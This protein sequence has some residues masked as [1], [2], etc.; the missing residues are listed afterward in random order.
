MDRQTPTGPLTILP[1]HTRRLSNEDATE[2]TITSA[3]AMADVVRS[4]LGPEG[5]DTMLVTSHG[6]VLVTNDGST[7]LQELH[8]TNPA[9]RLVADVASTQ[10][11][12]ASDGTTTA[13]VLAGEL[14]RRASGLLDQGLHP[15]TVAEGYR[16]ATARAVDLVDEQAVTIDPGD[17]AELTR[18]AAT[19]MTGTTTEQH[20]DALRPLAVEAVRKVTVE[21]DGNRIVDLHSLHI[22]SSEVG[23]HPGDSALL[24]GAVVFADP[25]HEAMPTS[26]EHAD[27]LLLDHP[28]EPAE[29]TVDATLHV[30][31]VDDHRR[32]RDGERRQATEIA[33]PILDSGVDV[34]FCGEHIDEAVQHE[35]ARAGILAVRRTRSDDMAFL[36]E[37]LGG[38][39]YTDPDA[40]D[41]DALVTGHVRRGEG[42]RAFHVEA[43][44]EATHGVT[45]LLRGS[46]RHALNEIER[47]V[48]DA[49]DT[50]ARAVSDGVVLPGA[51]ATEVA[52]AA[53]VR[54]HA[55]GVGGREQLAIEAFADALEVVPTV[56]AENAGLDPIDVLTDLRAAHRDGNERV[57]LNVRTGALEDAIE[58]GIYDL[59]GVKRQS[60]TAAGEIATFLL[61]I[62]DVISADDLTDGDVPDDD[63]NGDGDG[64][65]GPAGGLAGPTGGAI[66]SAAAKRRGDG[67]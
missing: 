67:S 29:P 63:E 33:R 7:L 1:N 23:G 55:A 57:G 53:G 56:L 17:D 22:E 58:A 49:I 39:I 37:V 66:E 38:E 30:E 60:I 34:V 9:A 32:F 45:F 46:I 25:V 2:Y 27:V 12:E 15:T 42:G 11:A 35:L 24:D 3:T 50:V 6:N 26:V 8:V 43:A 20:A 19:A 61:K 48:E 41:G 10:A 16:A 28:L 52:V 4:T 62:D 65:A 54:D 31:D 44:G 51:G 13:V 18:V 40:I 14:L 47:G 64:L 59:P 5:M 21:S 36:R